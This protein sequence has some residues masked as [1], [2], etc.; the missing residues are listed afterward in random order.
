MTSPTIKCVFKQTAPLGVPSLDLIAALQKYVD[1]LLAPAWG[2]H[3]TLEPATGVIPAGC[4][5]LFFSDDS[6]QAQALGYH[7]LDGLFPAGFV[8]V[9]TSAAAGVCLTETASHE[10][11]ELLLDPGANLAALSPRGHWVAREVCDPVQ[12]VTIPVNGLPMADFVLPSWYGVGSG[13]FDQAGACLQA[14]EV[15]PGG[16]VP[17]SDGQSWTQVFGSLESK[18]AFQ[19]RGGGDPL[20]R[21]SRRSR[22]PR[23]PAEESRLRL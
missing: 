8:F 14:W 3:A 6:D 19:K 16:Y 1:D 10:L 22:P 17:V 4:W 23:V 12:G 2:V 5:G 13:P 18:L 20:K 7:E 9:R 15:L 11:A 21:T